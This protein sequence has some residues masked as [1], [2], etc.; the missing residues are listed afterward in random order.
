MHINYKISL[1]TYAPL[2]AAGSYLQSHWE[3]LAPSACPDVTSTSRCCF[4]PTVRHHFLLLYTDRSGRNI[5]L[6]GKPKTVSWKNHW[7]QPQLPLQATHRPR[8]KEG[9]SF[10]GTFL[11]T[12]IP[13]SRTEKCGFWKAPVAG[14][15]VFVLLVQACAC[16]LSFLTVACTAH[17]PG[18]SISL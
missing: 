9:S 11:A 3:F 2:I 17:L 15:R 1:R 7:S 14:C 8:A 16:S 6:D 5:R 10:G 4:L 13:K 12:H 18:N